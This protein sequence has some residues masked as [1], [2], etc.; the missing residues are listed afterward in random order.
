MSGES[1][2]GLKP[3][4]V[5]GRV[6]LKL[7]EQAARTMTAS[8]P[9]GRT[10]TAKA[11]GVPSVDR[12]LEGYP[13]ISIVKLRAP[14]PRMPSITD[15]TTEMAAPSHEEYGFT[16]TFLVNVA[17][18]TDVVAMVT[19]LKKD[20]SVEDA[21][22]DYY[23]RALV[24]PND[25]F[26][27]GL[28]GLKMIN[29]D[30]AWD[31]TKGSAEVV[32]AIVDTGVDLNHPDLKEKL[33]AGFDMVNVADV[34]PEKGCAWEGDYATRDDNPDDENGHGTHC[35]GIAAG[36]PDNGQGIAG[37]AWN[38]QILPVRVLANLRCTEGGQSY[39][40][41]S[42]VFSDIADGIIWAADHGASVISLSLGGY[43]EKTEAEPEPMK[44]ALE[45]AVAKGCVIAAAMGNDGAN[46]DDEAVYNYPS[47][48]SKLIAVGAVSKNGKRADFSNFG[49]YKQVM[50]PGVGILSTYFGSRYETLDGTSMATPFVA[51]LAALIK[52]VD[53]RLTPAEIIDIIRRTS[54]RSD[55]Y[56][57]ESGYGIIDALKAA[58]EVHGPGIQPAEEIPPF[59]QE[60]AGNLKSTGEE[61]VYRIA[62]SNQLIMDL[63]GP[64]GADYD[65]YVKK[66]A[67]PTKE[68]YDARGY[69]SKASESVI[70]PITGPGEYYIMVRSHRGS[71]GFKLKT[72]LG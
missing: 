4:I 27:K 39:V 25:T 34:P 63:D 52:S 36:I 5:K 47:R 17:P 61:K 21:Q 30:K 19:D 18:D 33:R 31:L 69:T 28:W 38:C 45:Y 50:A 59:V 53:P 71:G 70:L 2:K 57:R 6:V 1:G 51:G 37:V 68:K 66:G 46:L 42:G 3:T 22:V 65:L 35:A 15:I 40:T 16:R 67:A 23:A 48:Y 56:D 43:V 8:I 14:A 44:S 12:V 26:F 72:R 64:E 32:V 62:V 54:S 7:K 10:S 9:T 60:V 55:Q 24:T 29:C 58:K 11:L 20:P 49:D 41:G 13:V